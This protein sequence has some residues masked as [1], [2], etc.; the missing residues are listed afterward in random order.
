MKKIFGI[1]ILVSISL[2]ARELT[3]E[4]AIQLAVDNSKDIKIAEISKDIS[5]LRLSKA[6]KTALPTVMYTGTYTASEYYREI[7]SSKGVRVND[8][9]SGYY[10][11]IKITQ[12]LFRGG[13][14]I[15]GIKGAKS[16]QKIAD[17]QYMLTKVDIRI[18]TIENY[19]E[20]IKNEDNLYGLKGALN[21]LKAVQKTQR[22][23]VSLNMLI[24]ADVLKTESSILE[25]NSQII[26][27]QTNIAVQMEL[28][29]IKTGI[30]KNEVIKIK[31]FSVPK[32]LSKTIDF[33]SDMR[34][35]RNDSIIA[36]IAKHSVEMQDAAKKIAASD[37][38]PKVNL[39]AS[40]GT[41]SERTRYRKT[42]DEA[43]WQGGIEVSWNVFDFGSAHDDYKIAKLEL[44]KEK[45]NAAKTDDSIDT[46]V[47][48]A[49]LEL[50]RL[51]K[52]R[53][54]KE[55]AVI[56]AKQNFEIDRQRYE[57]GL[58]ST[59]DYLR[60]EE[61]RRNAIIEHNQTVVK[62]MCAYERY[63]SLII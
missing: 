26:E 49:Y 54:S 42:I 7:S 13:A 56:A 19:A 16:Y 24:E 61:I 20:I 2:F 21:E 41:G 28:L 11:S 6:F 22:N 18:A 58:I 52:L 55:K 36:L 59:T 45:M 60:A 63:R 32:Y 39:F 57:E 62:Y 4:Q 8:Q 37:L 48:S 5:N 15:G 25:I 34:Q 38:L 44:E 33:E 3:L 31:E 47:T 17:L 35:A 14:I 40:Y 46:T 12:P 50:S 23:Q 43:S 9:K 51:E 10:Q 1:L 30:P 29:R 53:D 27:A